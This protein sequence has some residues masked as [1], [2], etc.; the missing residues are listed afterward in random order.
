MVRFLTTGRLARP[1]AVSLDLDHPTRPMGI[2]SP[3]T[4][5]AE[6]FV[7]QTTSNTRRAAMVAPVTAVVVLPTPPLA[8]P[9]RRSALLAARC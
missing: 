5:S 4:A 7:S 2:A 9:P 1:A 6:R 8:N 3:V